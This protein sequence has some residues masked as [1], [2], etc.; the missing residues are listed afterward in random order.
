VERKEDDMVA[1]FSLWLWLLLLLL[2]L[3]VGEE[4][5]A[6]GRPWEIRFSA[7]SLRSSAR[8]KN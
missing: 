7:A 2:L 5:G 6:G 1:E 4:K 8:S 3:K